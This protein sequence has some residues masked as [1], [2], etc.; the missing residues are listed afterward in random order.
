MHQGIVLRVTYFNEPRKAGGVAERIKV[1]DIPL[2]VRLQ[3][4]VLFEQYVHQQHIVNI[5]LAMVAQHH[6]IGMLQHSLA[7]QALHKCSQFLVMSVKLHLGVLMEHA[8][9]VT[10]R[11]QIAHFYQHN[12]RLFKIFQNIQRQSHGVKIQAAVWPFQKAPVFIK[13]ALHQVFCGCA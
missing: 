4:A 2:A 10:D 7:A 11:I 6:D 5:C 1:R 12:I 9:S 3:Q 8:E 13:I